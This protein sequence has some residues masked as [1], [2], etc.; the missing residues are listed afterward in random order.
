MRDEF[1]TVGFG[2]CRFHYFFLVVAEPFNF[3]YLLARSHGRYERSRRAVNQDLQGKDGRPDLYPRA[4]PVASSANSNSCDSA[5]PAHIC[6]ISWFFTNK[7]CFRSHWERQVVM[8]S[9]GRLT[10]AESYGFLQAK[11]NEAWMAT[12]ETPKNEQ[13]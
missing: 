5:L 3:W 7:Q 1:L 10:V 8:T 13:K 12:R 2:F 11:R 6:A 4:R 9:N